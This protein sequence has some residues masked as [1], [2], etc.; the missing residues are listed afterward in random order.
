MR[1]VDWR[2][3]EVTVRPPPT[4]A[5]AVATRALRW[6]FFQRSRWR[7][8]AALPVGVGDGASGLSYGCSC[9]ASPP[10]SA[11]EPWSCH[12]WLGDCHVG[13]TGSGAGAV[14][15]TVRGAMSGA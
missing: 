11:P 6:V 8:R 14:V 15:P 5:T 13:A 9:G 4:R 1:S 7:R 12:R 10:S 2:S 3:I